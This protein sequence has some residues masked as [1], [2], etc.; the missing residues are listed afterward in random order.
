MFHIVFCLRVFYVPQLFFVWFWFGCSFLDTKCVGGPRIP[1][2]YWNPLHVRKREKGDDYI[3]EAVRTGNV[4][5]VNRAFKLGAHVDSA[6][7]QS[8]L[9]SAALD[10]NLAMVAHLLDRGVSV[11]AKNADGAHL[12]D[13]LMHH[14]HTRCSNKDTREIPTEPTME[15]YDQLM[16]LVFQHHPQHIRCRHQSCDFLMVAILTG[17]YRTVTHYLSREMCINRLLPNTGSTIL[18]TTLTLGKPE[19]FHHVYAHALSIPGFDVDWLDSHHRSAFHYA[20]GLG[21]LELVQ[22]L[23]NHGQADVNQVIENDDP[24][25]MDDGETGLHLAVRNQHIPVVTWLLENTRVNVNLGKKSTPLLLAVDLDSPALVRL[26]LKHH[27]D[28]KHPIYP[29]HNVAYSAAIFGH[30]EVLKEL[31][32]HGVAMKQFIVAAARMGRLEVVQWLWSRTLDC[33]PA[34]ILHASIESNQPRVIRWLLDQGVCCC[35]RNAKTGLHALDL[36]QRLGLVYAVTWIQDRNN[37]TPACHRR[38]CV[39]LGTKVCSRCHSAW[40]CSSECRADAWSV[41]RHVCV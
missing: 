12:V 26:L 28:P 5:Q 31:Y 17:M 23:V 35:A 8:A 30:L 39:Q 9:L 25:A 4:H 38:K 18:I 6:P 27:A 29:A 37:R 13:V 3:L 32:A 40:Y 11:D 21:M 15:T 1:T 34:R 33:V 22:V 19:L 36:A 14:I 16:D 41:H 20:C 24:E 10:G 7:T 2:M